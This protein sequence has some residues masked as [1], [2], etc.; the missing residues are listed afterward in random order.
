MAM[1]GLRI[2]ADAKAVENLLGAGIR[3][4]NIREPF[5]FKS[6]ED[7]NDPDIHVRGKISIGGDQAR[8]TLLPDG[9]RVDN[10][11]TTIDIDYFHFY[12]DWHT[13]IGIPRE[14]S[15]VI[16][17]GCGWEIR[18]S[19]SWDLGRQK[20][21]VGP[22]HDIDTRVSAPIE[23]LR[24]KRKDDTYQ[25]MGNI[26]AFSTLR[27]ALTTGLIKKAL[28]HLGEEVANW[29]RARLGNGDIARLF[30]DLLLFVWNLPIRA[31]DLVEHRLLQPI[32]TA[33]E[34]Y[35]ERVFGEK[36]CE[37]ALGFNLPTS[38]VLIKKEGRHKAV[39]LPIP[40]EP[41]V[42]VNNSGLSFGVEAS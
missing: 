31:A 18:V 29:V 41:L 37:I 16:A 15:I 14:A 5:E 33:I 6:P 30:V 3:K 38:F 11:D 22:I 4:L 1:K 40:R 28:E 25:L 35:F 20:V 12:L 42:S 10:L 34:D 36:L 17:E 32:E 27:Y 8:C 23:G 7:S 21:V 9:L 2:R 26:A 39:V 19:W 24:F 13:V